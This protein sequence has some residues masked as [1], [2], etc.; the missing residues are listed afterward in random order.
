LAVFT[1]FAKN[2][3]RISYIFLS[4]AGLYLLKTYGFVLVNW[5]GYL[6]IFSLIK[7]PL[8]IT[9]NIAFGVS[10]LC[11]IA[12]SYLFAE[13]QNLKRFFLSFIPI[14]LIATIALVVYPPSNR[15]LEIFGLSVAILA[16]LLVVVVMYA[17]SLINHR[18][19]T[20][21]IVILLFSELF[22]LIP[23][24]RIPRAKAFQT[25]P[26][27]TFLKK[28][29]MPFRVYGISGCLFP[30]TATAFG[31]DD[32]GVYEAL[33]V[34]RFT[35]YIRELVDS[36]FF[37]E[38]SFHAFRG[39]IRDP[40]NVKYLILPKNIL[41]PPEH[42]SRLS[43]K[44]VYKDEVTIYERLNALPRIMIRHRA[45]VVADS[46][47][48]LRYLKN[49]YDICN[50]VLL[51]SLPSGV[52]L[53]PDLPVH[54]SSSVRIIDYGINSKIFAVNM[55][56]DG[57]LIVNDVNYPG[58]RVR[59]DG[60]VKELLSANYLFQSVFVPAGKHLVEFEFRPPS[61]L[62]GLLISVLTLVFI[63]LW[64]LS[65]QIKRFLKK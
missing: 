5:I 49:N 64:I 30:N 8:H 18:V 13:P 35:D 62:I 53:A 15:P 51:D 4:L 33:F 46:K 47:Q 26:Y 61:F 36:S 25:P 31:L 20:C 27:I 29:S 7:F 21:V 50:R 45:D 28:D 11:G 63:V 39:H 34:K 37:N 58:W 60:K 38:R 12:I 42:E 57:F 24:E 17:N 55:E 1:I 14:V 43:L 22:C 10:V 16:I 41:I 48:A 52:S 23:R 3:N 40:A 54:D 59:V 65:D 9:Q 6:P 2:K 44:V 56:H 19:V 32:I